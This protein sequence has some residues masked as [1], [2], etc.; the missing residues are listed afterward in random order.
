MNQEFISVLEE[1]PYGKFLSNLIVFIRIFEW[2]DKLQANIGA[3]LIIII[4]SLIMYSQYTKAIFP[5]FVIFV[6]YQSFLLSYG[7]AINTYA[8]RD[9]D[10]KVGKYRGIS[11]FSNIQ[12]LLIIGFLVFGCLGIPLYFTLYFNNLKLIVLGVIT[13]LLATFYS[14][15]PLRFKERGFL[16]ILCATLPQRPLLVLFFALLIPSD[17]KLVYLLILWIFSIGVIMEIGHQILDY[18]KDKKGGADTWATRVGI[19]IVKKYSIFTFVLFTI[20]LIAPIFTFSMSK[21]LAISFILL[22]FSGHS[23]NYFIENWKVFKS[24]TSNVLN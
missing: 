8:D 17:P 23:I 18:E 6:I 7:Y 22:A 20:S 10:S 16:G 21:G 19:S 4:A 11:Y 15:K 9:L 14:L 1:K 2:I 24:A 5:L 3:G 12:I 13:F